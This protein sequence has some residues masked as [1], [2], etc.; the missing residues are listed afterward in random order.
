MSIRRAVAD[1]HYPFIVALPEH[2]A[3][4]EALLRRDVEQAVE[5]TRRHIL[6]SAKIC[7]DVLFPPAKEN[8]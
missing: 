7:G 6:S 4:I 5:A 3:I 2:L 8:H 1:H